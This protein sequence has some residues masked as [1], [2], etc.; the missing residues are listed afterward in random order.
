MELNA[1]TTEKRNSVIS[2]INS[3]I[4]VFK[5]CVLCV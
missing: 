3:A 4:S 2:V 5:L 1:E